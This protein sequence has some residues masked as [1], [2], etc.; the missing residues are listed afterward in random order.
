[1]ADSDY[2]TIGDGLSAPKLYE[3]DEAGD[4]VTE[5]RIAVSIAAATDAASVAA[6]LA[7]AIAA[8]QPAIAVTDNLD[9]TLSLAHKIPG[10]VGNVTITENVNDAGFLVAGMSSGAAASNDP[11]ITQDTTYNLWVVPGER[12]ARIDKVFYINPTGLAGHGSNTFTL[13]LKNG[14]TV[15]A[16]WSTDTDDGEG[17]IPADEF[18]ELTL[19]ATDADLV[20][21]ADD[22]LSMLFDEGGTASLP[23]GRFLIHGR[24]L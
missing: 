19:S 14:E 1:M 13:S 2:I 5:G 21:V 7:T 11:N 17:S 3:F 8:N 10:A 4:G 15:M 20:A 16:S 6:I 24:Y 18:I 12:A 9:G 22:V 23:P